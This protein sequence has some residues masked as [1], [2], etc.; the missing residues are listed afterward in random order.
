ML[1]AEQCWNSSSTP[2]HSVG[3]MVDQGDVLI[4]D[5]RLSGRV[6]TRWHLYRKL[7]DDIC[8][9]RLVLCRFMRNVIDDDGGTT[10]ACQ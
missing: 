6:E 9:E 4:S 10:I 1:S 2:S 8:A 3:R 5:H 7:K